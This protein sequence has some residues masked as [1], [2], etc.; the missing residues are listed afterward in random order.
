HGA[1]AAP[2]TSPKSRPTFVG[3]VSIAPQISIAFFS[4]ISRA[5]DAPMGPTPY[6][7]ARI[8]F[9]T[10]GSPRF[11]AARS[12]AANLAAKINLYDSGIPELRQRKTRA[13][14]VATLNKRPA[15]YRYLVMFCGRARVNTLYERLFHAAT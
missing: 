11:P 15:D 14:P 10:K 9:F 1:S 5:M 4:R 8:F 13:S 3:S 6:W 2:T 12:H 7:M